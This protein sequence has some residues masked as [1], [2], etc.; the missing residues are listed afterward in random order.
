MSEALNLLNLLTQLDG[1]VE[2][3]D[4]VADRSPRAGLGPAAGR[5]WRTCDQGDWLLW[6]VGHADVS[7]HIPDSDRRMRL[8]ACECAETI[9]PVWERT[10][11][12]DGRPRVAIETSRRYV[13][14]KATNEELEAARASANSAASVAL[15]EAYAANSVAYAAYSAAYSACCAAL[16]DAHAAGSAAGVVLDAQQADVVRRH[17]PWAVVRLALLEV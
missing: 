4:W 3:T 13:E 7:P 14:G 10:Y 12:N 8:V 17:Y 1:C 9:L 11:P 6:L 15:D 16:N 2:G 5:L